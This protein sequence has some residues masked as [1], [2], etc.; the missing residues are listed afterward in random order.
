MAVAAATGASFMREVASGV[1]ESDMG[2][3][4]PDAADLLRYRHELDA[5]HVQVYMNITP[6]FASPLGSR[7]VAERAHSLAVSSL[8]DAI[9]IAGPMAGEEPD[10]AWVQESKDAVGASMPV[11]L[12]TGARI[13]NIAKFLKVADGAIVGSTL[14]VDGY[15][16]NPVDPARVKAFMAAVGSARR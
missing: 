15:T 10:L 9:L 6:E 13:E 5:D 2:L 12:N 7:T 1:Y 8:P 4:S 16:W 3:W 11:L 14:K